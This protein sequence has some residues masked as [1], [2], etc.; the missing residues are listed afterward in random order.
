MKKTKAYSLA[1]LWTMISGFFFL[2]WN[3]AVMAEEM[4]PALAYKELVVQVMPQYAEPEGWEQGEPAVLV[5]QHGVLTN[6]SDEEFEGEIR[7][8]VPVNEP[9]FELSLVGYFNEDNTVT[10]VDASL[11]E[12]T[13]ELVWSPGE[14]LQEGDTYRYVIEYFFAPIAEGEHKQFS[15]SY[16]LGLPA[17]T[18]NLLFVEPYGAENFTLSEEPDRETEM[19]GGPVHAFD[20]EPAEPGTSFDLEV[21]YDKEDTMTTL[22]ALESQT[23]P[24]DDVHAQFRDDAAPEA[25]GTGSSPL[26]DTESAV[27]I[28]LSIIIAG[29]FVFFGL[30]SRGKTAPPPAHTKTRSK[31][32]PEETDTK[33]LR[34]KLIRGEIDEETYRKERSKRS[35]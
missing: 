18:F 17:E 19:L 30:R 16:E 13:G 8:A 2:P 35:S 21:S 11:D 4:D 6:E 31:S 25:A 29:I 34:Q 33:A 1:M 26:I 24:D 9:S 7:I 32:K 14:N 20:S 23:P 27:M 10:D 28:S 15:Y 12:E 5:G 22:E 3:G